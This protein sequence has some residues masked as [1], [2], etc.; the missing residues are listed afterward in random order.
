MLSE[1]K[2]KEEMQPD[3]H[4][5]SYELVREIIKAYS[6]LDSFANITY[7]DLDA[8]YAMAIISNRIGIDEKKDKV[9]NSC[10]LKEDKNRLVYLIDFIWEKV[11]RGTVYSNVEPNGEHLLGMIGTGFHT[12]R[13]SSTD[14]CARRFIRMCVEISKED[15]EENIYSI[16]QNVLNSSFRGMQAASASAVL[17]CLKPFVFPILNRLALSSTAFN[18]MG[19]NLVR[20]GELSTYIDN[21]RRIAEFRN[22]ELPFKNYRIIDLIIRDLEDDSNTDI[23]DKSKEDEVIE[24]KENYSEVIK[25]DAGFDH[26]IILYGPP[27]TGKTYNTTIYSVAII[28]GKD[29]EVIKQEAEENYADVKAR[30]DEYKASGRVDFT[31]FHQSYGYEEFIEGIAPLIEDDGNKSDVA[32]RYKDGIF[33]KFCSKAAE[34]PVTRKLN[35]FTNDNPIVWKVSLKGAGENEVK[36]ECFSN[37]HIRIG[38]DG[39]GENISETTEYINGGKKV[40]EAFINRM[41][42]GDI[43]VTLNSQTTIDA[44]GVITGEPK[45]VD[46]YDKY[47]RVRSVKWILSGIN[48]D[49]T[50]YDGG[51]K[52]IE[53]SVYRLGMNQIDIEMLIEEMEKERNKE[54]YV[55]IVDEINRGNISKI[56]GELITLIENTKRKGMPEEMEVILPYTQKP[57]GVPNNVYILGTMNTADRSIA[58]MDTALRRRF[59]FIEM[60]PRPELLDRVV[61]KDKGESVNVGEMLR[62]INKRIEHLYDR[63]H[64]IGHAPFMK[65]VDEPSIDNLAGIFAKS[66]IPLLQEYFYEDYAKIR[67]VLGDNAKTNEED[68]FVAK[69]DFNWDDDFLGEQPEEVEN[70][71]TT[72]EIMYDN[73]TNIRCYQGI[74]EKL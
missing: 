2:S 36:S 71:D 37:S 12:F 25:T 20:P 18:M 27:G 64:T 54:P 3:S 63:E 58:L 44:I 33:K 70:I 67:M 68:Q 50:R 72:Y 9:R 42:I 10:L 19:I 35:Q 5:G 49:I 38:W 4:D 39:Y 11:R 7:L 74:I 17:H 60:L 46:S 29:V 32:Y 8:V 30:Y 31:T 41:N 55:F 59:S 22:K 34:T 65:L 69:R 53:T 21:C 28:E 61:V 57:F 66:V 13:N 48:A 6:K 62:I 1:L 51:K 26:N 43:V 14:E 45:W 47:K 40:L 73:F 23:V 15:D 52:L 16:A 24:M 56:F